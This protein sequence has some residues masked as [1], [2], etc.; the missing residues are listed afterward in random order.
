MRASEARSITTGKIQ[1]T[2]DEVFRDIRRVAF[3]GLFSTVFQQQQLSKHARIMLRQNGYR[4]VENG[5]TVTVAWN[6]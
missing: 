4:V 2:D 5:S 6:S 3:W 1:M